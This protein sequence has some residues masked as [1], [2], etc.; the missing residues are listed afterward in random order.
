MAFIEGGPFIC[1]KDGFQTNSVEEWNEHCSQPE[2]G[3]THITE[4]GN[5][6]CNTCFVPLEYSN[7]PFVKFSKTGSK[8]ISLRCEECTV[9][10]MGTATLRR[11]A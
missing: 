11:K 1:Y 6:L 7:L 4:E 8:T 9:K 5:T 10:T 3:T 2:N